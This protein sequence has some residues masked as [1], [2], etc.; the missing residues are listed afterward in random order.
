MLKQVTKN[1][2]VVNIATSENLNKKFW[3]YQNKKALN[4]AIEEN[5]AITIQSIYAL[6]SFETHVKKYEKLWNKSR[7]EF[8]VLEQEC[9][10]RTYISN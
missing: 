6:P 3:K 1:S 4:R 8:N 10:N 5:K 7:T 9:I 2:D